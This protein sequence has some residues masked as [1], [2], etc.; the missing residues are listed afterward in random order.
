MKIQK[1]GFPENFGYIGILAAIFLV[2]SLTVAGCVQNSAD[3]S[4]PSTAASSPADTSGSSAP[5]QGAG[6][7]SPGYSGQ[8][9]TGT[10]PMGGND[11]H[12]HGGGNFL[13]NETRLAAAAQ[14][15]GVSESD[16]KNALTPP[17]QARVNISAAAAQLGVTTDQ[18]TA[19]LGIPA[20]RFGNGTWQRGGYNNSNGGSPPGP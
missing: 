3:N 13:T 10:S 17:A 20:G 8:Q 6:S 5:A 4:G 14:T 11:T 7:T 18:L 2:M 15:L 19:A 1:P 12:Q 9:G 16:L